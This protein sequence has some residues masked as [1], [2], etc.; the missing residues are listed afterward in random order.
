MELQEQR[1]GRKKA[2]ACSGKERKKLTKEGWE[3]GRKTF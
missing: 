2:M 3:D 1:C